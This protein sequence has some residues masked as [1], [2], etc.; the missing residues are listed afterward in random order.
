MMALK[1]MLLRRRGLFTSSSTNVPHHKIPLQLREGLY[2][3]FLCSLSTSREGAG[4]RLRLAGDHVHPVHAINILLAFPCRIAI[5]LLPLSLA[6]VA[7][8]ALRAVWVHT[9]I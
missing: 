5:P 9:Y 2:S 3:L 8:L 7:H 6:L 1:V 4:L